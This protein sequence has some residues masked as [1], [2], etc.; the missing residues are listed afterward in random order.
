MAGFITN[1]LYRAY[2]MKLNPLTYPDDEATIQSLCTSMRGLQCARYNAD[3]SK[4]SQLAFQIARVK[5]KERM[6][7]RME[8]QVHDKRENAAALAADALRAAGEMEGVYRITAFLIDRAS[9]DSDDMYEISFNLFS[10]T[11]RAIL[12]TTDTRFTTKGRFEMYVKKLRNETIY[13]K[14]GGTAEWPVLEEFPRGA[15]LQL[16]ASS[17]EAAALAA[18][19]EADNQESDLGTERE[20]LSELVAGVNR[21]IRRI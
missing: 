5:D 14:N 4:L 17:S 20:A 18:K 6:I 9:E 3:R 12:K 21:T 15:A 8:G 16:Q 19:A 7:A 10:T 2:N 11:D 13:L 1:D